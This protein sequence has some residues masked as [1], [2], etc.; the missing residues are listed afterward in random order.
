MG[1]PGG[2][3]LKNVPAKARDT[4]D[5]VS[6]PE[7]GKSGGGGNGNPLHYSCLKNP[8]DSGTHLGSAVHGVS[9]SQT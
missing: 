9:Q 2:T 4:G 3:V 1:F 6:I 5:T 8:M 7:S